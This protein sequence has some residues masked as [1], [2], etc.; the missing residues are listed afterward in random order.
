M[1]YLYRWSKQIQFHVFIGKYYN[2]NYVANINI[3]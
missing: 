1:N 3:L 2:R